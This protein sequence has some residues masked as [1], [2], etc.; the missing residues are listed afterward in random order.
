MKFLKKAEKIE[1]GIEIISA[2]KANVYDV[3][4]EQGRIMALDETEPTHFESYDTSRPDSRQWEAVAK[5]NKCRLHQQALFVAEASIS[6]INR[7][8]QNQRKQ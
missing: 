5:R 3:S 6:K 4:I 7:I 1:L 8:F 2:M